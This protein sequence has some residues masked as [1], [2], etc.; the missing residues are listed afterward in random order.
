MHAESTSPSRAR[1]SLLG[2]YALALALICGGILRSL[3]IQDM[4][5]KQDERWSY[6]MSQE[7][8]R[9]QPWPAVGMATSLGFPN[10]GLSVWLFVPIGRIAKTPTAMVRAVVFLNMIGL[11]GFAAAVRAYLPPQEREPWLWGLA[12][13]AVSPFAIRMSRKIWPPSILTPLLLLLWISHRHRLSRWG[14]FAWGLVG[15]LIGQVHLSG[16]FVAVGLAAGTAVAEWRRRLPRSRFW[17]WWLLGTV[18]GSLTAMPWARALPSW[19][20]PA[21]SAPELL[22]SHI[23]GTVY[24]LAA[25]ATS[26]L[27]YS[28]LGLGRES[29]VFRLLPLVEGIPTHAFDLLSGFIVLA[30]VARM[31]GRLFAAVVVPSARWAWRAVARRDPD[32]SDGERS[33]EV[34]PAQSAAEYESTRF[35]LWSTIA[36]PCLIFML[37]TDVYFYHYYFVLCPFLFVAFAVWM[38]PW[39]RLLLV[40]VIAQALMSCLYLSYIHENGG[41]RRGEYGPT[42]ARQGNR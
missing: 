32:S 40:M 22:K 11:V 8:G 30:I 39:R 9:S 26:T 6:R 34:A 4:E 18:L 37:T 5:W 12:L 36:I 16:W 24:Y 21:R 13:Q 20:V 33:T 7:V 2:W 29:E 23:F 17:H 19:P 31:I 15:A 41:T 42:Y 27:P 25:S 38:L 35:Y 1:R 3:W 28:S 14:A 10:P